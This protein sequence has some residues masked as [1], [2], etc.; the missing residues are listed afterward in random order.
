MT[1]SGERDLDAL[2][3]L[4]AGPPSALD[5]FG[6]VRCGVDL[7]D[8]GRFTRCLEVGGDR[9]LSRI[10]TPAELA[11]CRGREERL[12]G[13]FAAKEAMAKLLGT[14]IRDLGWHEVEIV[15]DPA[16]EPNLRLHGRAVTRAQ[17]LGIR[18][19]ALS[20]G[21]ESAYAIAYVV[22][23]CSGVSPDASAVPHRY[24]GD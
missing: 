18:H 17:L 16:G 19:L 22:A 6:R 11:Y 7:V 21:H 9:F 3:G 23:S 1:M 4:G 24:E 5:R 20:L 15:T 8:I 12:A 2:L 13:R 10:F 14:G